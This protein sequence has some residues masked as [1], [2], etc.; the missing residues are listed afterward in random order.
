MSGMMVQEQGE[1][2]RTLQELFFRLQWSAFA[3]TM[4]DPSPTVKELKPLLKGQILRH[5][6]HK[7]LHK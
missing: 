7:Q 6:A 3:L 2:S 1:G 5:S 4:E